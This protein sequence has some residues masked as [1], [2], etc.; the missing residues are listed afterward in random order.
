MGGISVFY[1]LFLIW[2][3]LQTIGYGVWTWQKQNKVGAVMV[4]L[5]AIAALV[6]PVYQHFF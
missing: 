1:M 4:F 6:F 3:F 2:V 5:L